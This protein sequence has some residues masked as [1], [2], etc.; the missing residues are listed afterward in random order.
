MHIHILV[1]INWSINQ[2][3]H[4]FW[5]SSCWLQMS[6]ASKQQSILVLPCHLWW[7][8]FFNKRTWANS[9]P[10]NVSLSTN[11][12]FNVSFTLSYSQFPLSTYP[13]SISSS[14]NIGVDSITSH[15]TPSPSSPSNQALSSNLPIPT[16]SSP[17]STKH[18]S[19]A[20]A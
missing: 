5:L 9:L 16:P 15:T 1:C 12:H 11:L 3:L 17:P 19:S 18:P 13:T 6:W 10:S 20:Y 8:H 14:T 4:V 2:P 7:E